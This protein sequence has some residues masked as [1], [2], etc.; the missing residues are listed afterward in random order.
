MDPDVL[1]R[2]RADEAA[3]IEELSDPVAVGHPDRRWL[4]A[5]AG[6]AAIVCFGFVGSAVAPPS[7]PTSRS[8]IEVPAPTD[9]A[10]AP[11][12]DSQ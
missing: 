4:L 11:S 7:P 1:G 10:P 8:A 6:M 5:I 9:L 3:I 2:G 12:H